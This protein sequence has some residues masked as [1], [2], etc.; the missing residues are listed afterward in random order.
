[1]LLL[2]MISRAKWLR[3][4]HPWLLTDEIQ[5]DA[6]S[7]L[8]TDGNKL[9]VWEILEDQSNLE[10]VLGA[11]ASNWDKP[12]H[13]DYVIVESNLLAGPGLSLK[14]EKED[15]GATKHR[16]ADRQWHYNLCELTATSVLGLAGIVDR[17]E[18]KAR[19]TKKRIIA[20]LREEVGANRIEGTRLSQQLRDVL[21]S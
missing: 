8:K 10:Q 2:R 13:L 1:M 9:S 3:D 12:Q 18:S 14:L 11:L 20:I 16:A 5:S 21:V 19:V 15:E 17:A 6:L 4:A 7:D